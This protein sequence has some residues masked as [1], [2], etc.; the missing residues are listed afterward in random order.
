ME[1]RNA[2]L[3]CIFGFAGTPVGLLCKPTKYEV[4]FE[5]NKFTDSAVF[6]EFIFKFINKGLEITFVC[7]NPGIGF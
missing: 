1:Q 3:G 4:C 6:N 5:M 7:I 2:T